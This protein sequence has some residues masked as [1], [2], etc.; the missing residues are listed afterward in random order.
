MTRKKK[1]P[2]NSDLQEAW[3]GW[4]AS[5]AHRLRSAVV[6]MAMTMILSMS[7]TDDAPP[8]ENAAEVAL[9][10]LFPTMTMEATTVLTKNIP[11]VA[12][13]CPIAQA[14][15]E[16]R[17]NTMKTVIAAVREVPVVAQKC[18]VSW[19]MTILISDL[20]VAADPKAQVAN[21]S[22]RKASKSIIMKAVVADQ[23][24]PVAATTLLS[25]ITMM[26][27]VSLPSQQ[28]TLMTAGV[29]RALKRML[30]TV[31]PETMEKSNNS[32]VRL[33]N[34]MRIVAAPET[35]AKKNSSDDHLET[36]KKLWT[37][38]ARKTMVRTW[39][40]VRL[41]KMMWTVVAPETMMIIIGVHQ[42]S[43]TIDACQVK[44]TVVVNLG[45][46]VCKCLMKM[47]MLHHLSHPVPNAGG[48]WAQSRGMRETWKMSLM[49]P[50][51]R[52]LGRRNLSVAAWN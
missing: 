34:L 51:V 2:W 30:I 29:P 26:H 12:V 50:I 23:K 40:A 3:V 28:K 17:M 36:K 45:R 42:G 43:L 21:R 19:R 31:A 49:E 25:L 15:P 5:A 37:A 1:M 14:A 24:A 18:T 4:N 9:H 44:T 35:S 47:R 39:T 48:G 46:V 32:D 11:D 52:L 27:L 38:V 10:A 13:A 8:V 20:V 22:W 41:R 6:A 33:E 7:P 16:W